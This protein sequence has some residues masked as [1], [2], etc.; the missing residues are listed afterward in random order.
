MTGHEDTSVRA[1]R[2]LLRLY[3]FAFRL[4]YGEAMERYFC[5]CC[6]DAQRDGTVA[7]FS[8]WAHAL[9]DLV[10]NIF[11]A[12]SVQVIA[13]VGSTSTYARL[14]AVSSL[15]LGTRMALSAMLESDD[16]I[17]N[18]EDPILAQFG[19]WF[20]ISIPLTMLALY[21]RRGTQP[22][23]LERTGHA[24]TLTGL[25]IMLGLVFAMWVF[26]L[27][28][29]L[30]EIAMLTFLITL[31]GFTLTG[32]GRIADRSEA[33]R[34]P[35]GVAAVLVGVSGVMSFLCSPGMYVPWWG[36]L[37]VLLNVAYVSS[38]FAWAGA[39]LM[40]GVHLWPE[41]PIRLPVLHTP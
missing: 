1:Y 24:I 8:L 28:S 21:L 12:R 13:F 5:D 34:D 17:W 31:I 3:P 36:T 23:R 25:A 40:F 19:G 6:R 18:G 32:Y 35:L 33:R 20:L 4:E 29:P 30:W 9:T 41:R 14:G 11:K 2:A 16:T 10:T 22:N 26:K 27:D 7:I 15:M 39:W 37:P 38:M